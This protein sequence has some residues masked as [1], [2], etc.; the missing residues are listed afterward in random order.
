MKIPITAKVQTIEIKKNVATGVTGV[1]LE[2]T[3]NAVGAKSTTTIPLTASKEVSDLVD[4]IL[5]T[6][7]K[8]S[9]F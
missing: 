1:I 2:C 5:K 6:I 8:E 7:I 4:I 3:T 9:E